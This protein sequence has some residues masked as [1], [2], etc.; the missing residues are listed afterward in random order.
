MTDHLVY[1]MPILSFIVLK[2]N[3]VYSSNMD[4][5]LGELQMIYKEQINQTCHSLNATPYSSLILQY[6][7]SSFF[8]SYRAL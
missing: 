1:V 5:S 7:N 4:S 6:S 8:V 2:V 3:R